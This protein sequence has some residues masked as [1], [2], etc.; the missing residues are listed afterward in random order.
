MERFRGVEGDLWFVEEDEDE[1][2]A[3]AEDSLLAAEEAAALAL[4]VLEAVLAAARWPLLVIFP[5][6]Y[7]ETRLLT[8]GLLLD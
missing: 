3:A 1:E 4:E 5:W 8:A 6:R 2:A 7:C